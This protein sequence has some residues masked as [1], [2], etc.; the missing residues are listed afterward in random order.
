M[1]ERLKFDSPELYDLPG[2]IPRG[3]NIQDLDC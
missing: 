3:M 2:A 1:E